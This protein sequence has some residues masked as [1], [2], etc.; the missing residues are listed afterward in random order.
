MVCLSRKILDVGVAGALSA[1]KN[2]AIDRRTAADDPNSEPHFRTSERG[3]R[4]ALQHLAA[5]VR[6]CRFKRNTLALDKSARWSSEDRDWCQGRNELKL[7][8]LTKAGH[9]EAGHPKAEHQ[10]PDRESS[11]HGTP[12]NMFLTMHAPQYVLTIIARIRIFVQAERY[13][14]HVASKRQPQD[15]AVRRAGYDRRVAAAL[16][17]LSRVLAGPSVSLAF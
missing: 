1:G 3:D 5:L 17:D 9:Y 10:E 13:S 8:H 14:E 12:R 6:V 15:I 4:P 16:L 7:R 11:S 2:P